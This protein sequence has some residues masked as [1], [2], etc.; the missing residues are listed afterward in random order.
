MAEATG[1]VE[2]HGTRGEDLPNKLHRR[3]KRRRRRRKRKVGKLCRV[4]NS[5]KYGVANRP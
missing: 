5:Y 3:G 4:Y 1:L 2:G